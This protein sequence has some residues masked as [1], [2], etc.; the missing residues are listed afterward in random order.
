MSRKSH[1]CRRNSSWMSQYVAFL[2]QQSWFWRLTMQS[3]CN[4]YSTPPLQLTISLY[5]FECTDN[6]TELKVTQAHRKM[7]RNRPIE[8][9]WQDIYEWYHWI[10][11]INWRRRKSIQMLSVVHSVYW[12]KFVRVSVIYHL[13]WKAAVGSSQHNGR[14]KDLMWLCSQRSMLK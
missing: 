2:L 7:K 4:S 13:Q 11:R 6:T 8:N 12:V 14:A 5:F 3:Y 10:T 9:V 1:W